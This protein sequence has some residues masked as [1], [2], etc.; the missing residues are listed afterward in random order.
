MNDPMLF[1]PL[2]PLLPLLGFLLNGVLGSR[3]PKAL[4]SAIALIFPL[5]SF[6]LVARAAWMVH[7]GLALPVVEHTIKES[8]AGSW[9]DGKTCCD[10]RLI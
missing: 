10:F 9:R 6:A 7:T 8:L 5:A 2:I 4:V 1:L 3:L